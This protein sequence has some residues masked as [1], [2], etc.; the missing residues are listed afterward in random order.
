MYYNEYLYCAKKHLNGCHS[1]FQSYPSGSV[2]DIH[3]WMELY[4]LSGYI[5]EGI[6]VYA[7]YKL[8]NWPIEVDIIKERDESFTQ[9]TKLDFWFDRKKS[10]GTSVFENRIH[11]PSALSVQKHRFQNIVKNLLKSNPATNNVPYIGNGN[12]DQDVELLI[13]NWRPDIRYK[14][15]GQRNPLSFLNEDIIRRLLDT[16]KTICINTQTNI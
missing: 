15:V 4:Y 2:H 12:I 9:R 5:I 16:C 1:L 6:T 10:D 13:E 7:A 8:Y 11:D 14:Y 3:V